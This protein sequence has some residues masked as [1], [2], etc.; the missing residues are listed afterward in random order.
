MDNSSFSRDYLPELKQARERREKSL[1]EIKADSMSR[2][3]KDLSVDRAKNPTT[4][5]DKFQPGEEDD[6]DDDGGIIDRCKS[7][8][9]GPKHSANFSVL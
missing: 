6:E 9:S 3:M 1:Q 7:L 8:L 5:T 4:F 2:L